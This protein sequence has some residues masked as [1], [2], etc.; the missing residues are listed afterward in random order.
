MINGIINARTLHVWR[1]PQRGIKY[2][3]DGKT[4]HYRH[5]Y[6]KSNVH[7]TRKIQSQVSRKI[8]I[9]NTHTENRLWQIT[10]KIVESIWMEKLFLTHGKILSIYSHRNNCG[11]NV[12]G[13]IIG[14]QR[15][16]TCIVLI[17]TRNGKIGVGQVAVAGAVTSPTA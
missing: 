13:K 7:I 17:N 6:G 16:N 9:Q 3:H 1:I 4:T 12:C 2:K 14:C 10:R 5:K 11:E 8:C 15:K